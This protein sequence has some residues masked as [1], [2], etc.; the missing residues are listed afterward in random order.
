VVF[1]AVIGYCLYSEYTAEGLG[2]DILNIWNSRLRR[3]FHNDL[4]P[5]DYLIYRKPK[6][7]LRPG[8]RAL[9]VQPAQKGDDY[10]YEVDKYWTLSDI[11]DDGR[12]VAVTRTGKRVYL[13]PEDE[14]LRKAGLLTRVLHRD[15][16]P[17]L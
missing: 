11:L 16:F 17:S 1:P 10:R 7:S 4:E 5:G 6:A 9:N 2:N 14:R 13:T 8:P 3:L 12:L 15:R